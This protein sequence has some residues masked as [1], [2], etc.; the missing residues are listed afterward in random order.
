MF[1]GL[2]CIYASSFV[3]KSFD[4]GTLALTV[5]ILMHHILTVEVL[6]FFFALD[7]ICAS[8]FVGQSFDVGTLV[9]TVFMHPIFVSL[10]FDVSTWPW[11]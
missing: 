5:F 11:L 9:L 4:V 6:T 8:R 2:N 7:C 3:S 1:F 10:R